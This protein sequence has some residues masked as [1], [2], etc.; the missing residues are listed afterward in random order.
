[1]QIRIADL[2][3]NKVIKIDADED[4]TIG[5]LI[6]AIKEILRL[7]DNYLYSLVHGNRELGPDTHNMTLSELGIKEGDEL[8]ILGRPQGG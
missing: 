2:I 7:P 4:T 5:E 1:M 3:S 6:D 8:Q